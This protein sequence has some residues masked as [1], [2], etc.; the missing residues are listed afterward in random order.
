M[1]VGSVDNER[2][3]N[4]GPTNGGGPSGIVLSVLA[5]GAVIAA[6]GIWILVVLQLSSPSID[7]TKTQ[8]WG[9]IGD[10]FGV[11]SALFAALAFFGLLY[12]IRLQRRELKESADAQAKQIELSVLATLTDAYNQEIAVME[13]GKFRGLLHRAYKD[14]IG[15]GGGEVAPEMNSTEEIQMRD[16]II[17]K[18]LQSESFKHTKYTENKKE[19]YSPDEEA[20]FRN[21]FNR[22]LLLRQRRD[23]VILEVKTKRATIGTDH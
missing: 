20:A 9:Q 16:R 14:V 11:V 13:Q 10:S 12:T 4:T 6:L 18:G 7:T 5:T 15:W 19:G 17:N 3:H 1:A 8:V 21:T 22:W 23:E 2:P